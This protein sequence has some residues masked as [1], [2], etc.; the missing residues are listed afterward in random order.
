MGNRAEPVDKTQLD[1]NQSKAVDVHIGVFF[2]GTG[3]H[4]GQAELGAERRAGNTQESTKWVTSNNAV[5]NVAMLHD[6][7]DMG[8]EEY[9]DRVYI[10]GVGVS[11]SGQVRPMGLMIGMG[12][13]S[14]P[15]KVEKAITKVEIT[16]KDI[17]FGKLPTESKINLYID[18]FG[19]SR[20]AAAARFFIDQITKRREKISKNLPYRTTLNNIVIN[21]VGLYDT[22]SSYGGNFSN[23]VQNLKLDSVKDAKKVFQICAADE[24]RSFYALTNINSAGTKG[25]ELFLPGCHTDIGGGYLEGKYNVTLKDI[26]TKNSNANVCELGFDIESFKRFGWI[27]N[28]DKHKI[29]R[30]IQPVSEYA[31]PIEYDN[32]SFTNDIK[33]G[34]YYPY[35]TLELMKEYAC[36]QR[37]TIFTEIKTKNKAPDELSFIKL[38]A[39]ICTSIKTCRELFYSDYST[40]TKD[41]LHFSSDGSL[42]NAPRVIN[43]ILKREIHNG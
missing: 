24:F 9:V 34:Y 29:N 8:G 5:S 36:K 38:N 32:L 17:A 30:V 20:G 10:E 21:F 16:V 15:K 40:L 42:N 19:F 11:E 4:K 22:V 37:P 6:I 25:F 26:G 7:Y 13:Q 12:F 35:V 14:I 39:P 28:D 27:R 31:P 43:K 41:W 2:E 3:N 23:D 1:E 18:A 33:K